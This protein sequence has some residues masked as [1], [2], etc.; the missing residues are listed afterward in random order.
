MDGRVMFDVLQVVQ[1]EYKLRSY[2]LNSVSAE[3]LGEQKEDVQPGIISDLFAGSPDDRRR[4]A[5]YCLKVSF[6][7]SSSCKYLFN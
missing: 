7:P 2:T 3:Y 6:S 4:L 5:T 1:R